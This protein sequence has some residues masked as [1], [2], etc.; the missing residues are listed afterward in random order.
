MTITHIVLFQF[1]QDAPLEAVLNA[2]KRMLSLKDRC[3]HSSTGKPYIQS[4]SG[5]KDNSP[6]GAQGSITHAFI[7]EF[8]TDADRDFYV[9]RG[10]VHQEFVRSLDGLIERALVV[11]FTPGVLN[12]YTPYI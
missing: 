3:L 10:H 6:E 8:A 5:E 7:F 11:D 4:A 2:C 12:T 1:E 9:N